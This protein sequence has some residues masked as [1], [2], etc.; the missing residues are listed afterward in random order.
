MTAFKHLPIVHCSSRITAALHFDHQQREEK[1]EHGQA[2]A[3][4]VHSFVADQDIT[5]DDTFLILTKSRDLME[6]NKSL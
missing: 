2:E 1:I 6:R 4:A 5:R 3:Q